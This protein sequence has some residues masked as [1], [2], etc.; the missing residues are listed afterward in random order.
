MVCA[1]VLVLASA[2]HGQTPSHALGSVS[3][4]MPRASALLSTVDMFAF[5]CKAERE[6]STLCQQ[7][8]RSSKL[9]ALQ[10]Q[11]LLTSADSSQRAAL[12]KQR[13]AMIA[14]GRAHPI[15][16]TR[17][18]YL[19]MK[20]AYC[21]TEPA[22]SK[23]LCAHPTSSY[24]SLQTARSTPSAITWYCAIPANAESV[25]CKR[26]AISAKM[27]GS[28]PG[29]VSVEE[30]KKLLE[31]LKAHPFNYAA[32]Q[33][34]QAD[35]C[36]VNKHG[37]DYSCLRLKQTQS[38]AAMQA[39]HCARPTSTDSAWCKRDALLKKL[40][41]LTFLAPKPLT[42]PGQPSKPPAPSPERV[43]L[44]EQLRAISSAS[45]RGASGSSGA[46]SVSKELADAKKAYCQLSGNA[47]TAY[48]NPKPFTMSSRGVQSFPTPRN[49]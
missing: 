30:R 8:L 37:G 3:S 26:N 36:K 16:S 33:A 38:Q 13:T 44:L 5:W 20:E 21:A 24:S 11:I 47:G 32:M 39:W 19:E 2:V 6:Q 14:E 48:C 17:K 45:R 41:A 25:E 10:K 43:A 40:R 27:R 42:V 15:G 29:S 12:T 4:R 28:Q 34:I 46:T 35:F 9:G 7:R 23:V 18:E 31:E 49:G 22:K 1:S